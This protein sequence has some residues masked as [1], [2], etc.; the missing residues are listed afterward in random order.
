MQ[1]QSYVRQ[2]PYAYTQTLLRGDYTTAQTPLCSVS[3][4]QKA[5]NSSETSF[6]LLLAEVMQVLQELMDK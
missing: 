1:K 2:L 3:F 5:T 6:T 4:L